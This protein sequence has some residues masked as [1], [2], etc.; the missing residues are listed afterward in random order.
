MKQA[1]SL[2]EAGHTIDIHGITSSGEPEYHRIKG[3]N[4][5]VFLHKKIGLIDHLTKATNTNQD[6]SA[7]NLFSVLRVASRLFPSTLLVC[8]IIGILSLLLVL[9]YYSIA[10]IMKSWSLLQISL[11]QFACFVV[12][13]LIAYSLRGLLDRKKEAIQRRIKASVGYFRT[14]VLRA[15]K[16]T[17]LEA[18]VVRI[19]F[20]LMANALANGVKSRPA[21]DV[22]HLHD[23]VALLTAKEL[24]S[25]FNT[26]I[27][28][29]AHE[30]YED[31][32]AADPKRNRMNAE[33]VS[34][35][36]T[37]IDGFVTIN[38]SIAEFYKTKYR[39]LPEPVVV[40]NATLP[41][42][43]PVYDGRLHEAAGLDR[44][45]KIILFQGGLS[46]KR[47][48][49]KL[50][51]AASQF[52]PD[53]TLVLMGWGALEEELRELARTHPR[54][55]P[56][57][58]VF[59]PGVPR[60]E[61]SAWSAGATLGA[62]P[63]ENTGLNHLYCTPNKLWEYPCAGVPILCTNL[64]E[65]AKIVRQYDLGFLIPRDFTSQNIV[66]IVN[67]VTPE[68]LERT[69]KNCATFIRKNNWGTYVPRLIG[70]YDQLKT[71]P[72]HCHRP[73]K[74]RLLRSAG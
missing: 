16:G 65:M 60:A 59:V 47:G 39:H 54:R 11:A 33:N 62:I 9:F 17:F 41:E 49:P 23:H 10:F 72:L 51:R 31:L 69:K 38:D 6:Q 15:I 1:Q 45:Q 44:D 68:E 50:V 43:L 53:W 71:V 63:Y 5:N 13:I 66:Q 56:Q 7:L 21:P 12:V 19:S 18:S 37:I 70:L 42:S 58:V 48:L 4:I 32:A 34:E 8:N 20:D 64:I 25:T 29:D 46:A 3:T 67:G 28:W 52:N 24:K 57:A 40:M 2:W 27:I 74:A 14:G 30:I 26:P 22:I 36:S 73:H 61:L 35:F 55:G